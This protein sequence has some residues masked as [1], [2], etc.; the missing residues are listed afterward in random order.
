[1]PVGADASH[2]PP[3]AQE[4]LAQEQQAAHEQPAKPGALVRPVGSVAAA[5]GRAQRAI[6]V[7]LR[8]ALS[9]VA[10]NRGALLAAACAIAVPVAFRLAANRLSRR[11]RWYRR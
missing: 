11:R 3:P 7:P 6:P 2:D 8:R 4:K 9:R 10:G 5:A 1:V